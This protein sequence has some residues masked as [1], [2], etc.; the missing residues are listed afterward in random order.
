MTCASGREQRKCGERKPA[1]AGVREL[2]REPTLIGGGRAMK[3]SA[4][5]EKLCSRNA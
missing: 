2:G 3:V 1:C 5:Y 4:E